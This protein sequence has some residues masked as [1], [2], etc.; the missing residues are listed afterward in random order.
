MVSEVVSEQSYDN[1]GVPGTEALQMEQRYGEERSKRLREDGVDQF[2]D[3]SLSDKFNHFQEDPFVDYST[4]KDLDSMFPDKTCQVLI[5]G[6]GFGGLM[7]AVRMIEAGI[8]PEDIRIIDTAGGFGGTWYFNRYPGLTCDIESHCYLPLLEE[9]GYMPKHRYSHGSEIRDYANLIAEKYNIVNSAVFL[10]KAEELRWDEECKT[11]QVALSQ[12]RKDQAPQKLKIQAQFVATVNGVLNWPKLPGLPGIL[13]YKG[14]TFHSSRWDYSLTGGSPSDPS[15]VKLKDKR[16]AIVGTGC[17]AVQIIPHL[18][19]SAKHLYVIQR[20][21]AAVDSRDQRVT[22]PEWFKKEVATSPGWQRE[23]LRNFHQHFTTGKQPDV[24]LV[25]DEWTHAVGMV[26]IAGN[27]LGPKT[28]DDLPEYM[29]VLHK[30]DDPR[31]NRIRARVDSV[32]SDPSDAEKLKAWYPTWCKRPAF[33]NEYLFTFNRPNV[34]L[35]DTDGKGPS[36]LTAN[37]IVANGESYDVDLVIFAT[38]F[39]PPYGGTPAEKANLKIYGRAGVSMTDEWAR[40]G[41][42]TLHGVLDSNFP[43]LFLSGPWQAST[44]PNFLFGVD[45]LGKH[46]AYILSESKRRAGGKPFEVAPTKEATQGWALQVLMRSAPMAAIV[47]CT[48]SYFN[49]EG[50]IDKAPPEVQ[51]LMAKSGLWGH[52]I[53]DYLSLIHI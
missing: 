22:D 45:N 21:A 26:P 12:Q 19:Q 41:P 32:V 11:W 37:S 28:P 10:T 13:D 36:H 16:V 30:L 34:T 51:M 3:I 35:V 46:A 18:A 29:E 5:L 9:T 40:D 31:Q 43:N 14:D 7:Y 33:H 20:T 23:R 47:G 17:S 25:N 50:A 42:S 15:L 48:P 1:E 49:L 52:G 27:K 4:V 24:N 44:S 2:V 8:R 39:R 53:E 6:A 38:G